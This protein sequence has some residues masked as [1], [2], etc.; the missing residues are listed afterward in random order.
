[1][2]LRRTSIAVLAA[3]AACVSLADEAGAKERVYVLSQA[4][5]ALSEIED[6]AEKTAAPIPLDKAP[7]ALVLSSDGAQAYVSHPD[8]G[9]V[10]IVDLGQRRVVSSLTVAGSPFGLAVAKD[11]RLFVGDW[12]GAHVSVID[13]KGQA[14]P[15]TVDVGRA[16]A[17][18]ILT[19]DE[20]LLFIANRES[21]SVSVVRTEDLSVAATIAVDRAPFAMAL[22]PDATRLYVG[23]VQGGTV[24]IVDTAGFK[25]TKTRVSG[26][27]P[28]GA[29]VTG[30]GLRLVVTNQQASTVSVIEAKDAPPS[31]IK[32]GGYPE[33]V[34]INA[35]GTRAYVAN[36][37]S[38]DVSVLDLESL[39]EIRRIK[40]PQGPRGIAISHHS[41]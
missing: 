37:F 7:A 39:K 23:N 5:A 35:D 19:P 12:N 3:L 18:L 38:D 27:M 20:K 6:G 13:T 11:G 30:D 36:W 22:S 4:G 32:V 8:I 16:P 40:C 1:M 21:D 25:V 15:R 41:P 26:A 2:S 33:G 10:S 34:A 24:S 28:Y 31:V 29:A 17:H 14:P 9:K